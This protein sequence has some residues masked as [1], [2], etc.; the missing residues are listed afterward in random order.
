MNVSLSPESK[1][2][3]L[4][5]KRV[6]VPLGKRVSPGTGMRGSSSSA[7][8]LVGP[9]IT[10]FDEANGT[11]F[12]GGAAQA[13]DQL[14]RE[15]NGPPTAEFLCVACNAFGLKPSA[16]STMPVRQFV[17]ALDQSGQLKLIIL[18]GKEAFKAVINSGKLPPQS[19]TE[20][21]RLS[22]PPFRTE[23]LTL[24]SPE[25]LWF[26]PAEDEFT[27]R[28]L[29]RAQQSAA[30]LYARILQPH[31]PLLNSLCVC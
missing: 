6:V 31:V 22:I 25:A 12:G 20:G 30:R 28:R 7:V 23:I 19:M 26:P 18:V 11:V 9:P 3:S 10:Q 8:L 14:L 17:S 21:R 24:P 27:H 29:A 1:A 13:F 15:A 4:F 16:E 2:L 5:R